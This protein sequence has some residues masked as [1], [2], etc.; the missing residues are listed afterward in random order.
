VKCPT[1]R[2][3]GRYADQRC[4]WC[5]GSGRNSWRDTLQPSIAAEAAGLIEAIAAANARLRTAAHPEAAEQAA[6]ELERLARE[7]R[8][9]CFPEARLRLAEAA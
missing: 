6:I 4:P 9:L 3:T 8:E 7:L 5:D 2:G 1:C